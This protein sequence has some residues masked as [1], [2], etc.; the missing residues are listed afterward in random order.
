MTDG[1][2]EYDINNL[3]RFLNLAKKNDL[4]IGYRKKK[5]YNFTRKIVSDFYNFLVRKL[6]KVNFKDMS[7]GA[8]FFNKKILNKFNLFS[9]GPFIGAELII[10]TNFFN[11]RI[12][13]LGVKHKIR[14]YGDGSIV[15]LKNILITFCQLIKL[16]F[17]INNKKK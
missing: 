15:N 9:N 17:I 16:F 2:D 14:R 1:D 4:V 12:S 7:A 6:F 10:K 13:E 3:E 5:K 11:Y 8:R